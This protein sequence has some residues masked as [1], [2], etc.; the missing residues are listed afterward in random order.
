MKNFKWDYIFYAAF[1]IVI[2]VTFI[3]SYFVEKREFRTDYNFE[4]TDLEITA[5]KEVTLYS[6][7]RRIAF[8]LFSLRERNGIKKGDFIVKKSYSPYLY[9]YRKDSLG[10]K[11]L[12]LKVKGYNTWVFHGFDD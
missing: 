1:I 5:K 7:N 11:Q 12:Y 2:A 4:V 9:I 8:S 10:V 6:G 3:R